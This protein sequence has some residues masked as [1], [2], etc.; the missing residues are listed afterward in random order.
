MSKVFMDGESGLNLIFTS[1][2]K[3]VGITADMLQESNT[4]FHGIVPTLPR[5]PLSRIS[6]NVIFGK[7]DNFR[8]ERLE[9]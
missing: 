9:F 7:P 1:T 2:V 8:R 6:L 5:Y 3:A 4:S